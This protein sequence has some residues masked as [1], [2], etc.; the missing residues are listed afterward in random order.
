MP[1]VAWESVI[2]GGF[3]VLSGTYFIFRWRSLAREIHHFYHRQ[4]REWSWEP[5]WLRWRPKPTERQ[6]IVLAW[7][8][9][10]AAEATGVFFLVKAAG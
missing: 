6:A 7:T 8:L 9:I 10:A 1:H 5:A 2:A 3:L 4:V